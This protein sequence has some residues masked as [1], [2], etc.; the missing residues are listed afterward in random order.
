MQRRGGRGEGREEGGE[1]R[2]RGVEEVGFLW[3]EN[4]GG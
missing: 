2:G 3:N 4:E 1:R